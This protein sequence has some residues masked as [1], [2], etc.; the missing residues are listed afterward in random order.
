TVIAL[1]S[2]DNRRVGFLALTLLAVPEAGARTILG[3]LAD[4]GLAVGPGA[5]DGCTA[6][7]YLTPDER[8]RLG[9]R[10]PP[11]PPPPAAA[12]PRGAPRRAGA[13]GRGFRRAVQGLVAG[14]AP[15]A[16]GGGPPRPAGV[17]VPAPVRARDPELGRVLDRRL[18]GV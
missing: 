15:P 9:R 14:A 17:R 8:E 12:R 10:F 6:W 13:V 5:F 7:N 18:L 11:P 4:R 16:Q 2:D 1:L 3:A